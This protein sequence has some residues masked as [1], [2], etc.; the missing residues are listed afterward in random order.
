V[1]I[2]IATAEDHNFILSSWLKSFRKYSL[3]KNQPPEAIYYK[4][5]QEH[6]KDHLEESFVAFNS[7]EPDQIIGWVCYSPGT[8]HFAYVKAPFRGY[9]FGRQLIAMAS[10]IS[11]YTHQT[12]GISKS[13]AFLKAVYNPYEF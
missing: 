3:N 13:S 4:H 2:E 8:F 6:I 1:K 7:D 11:Q 5:H 9:G 10:P 12:R